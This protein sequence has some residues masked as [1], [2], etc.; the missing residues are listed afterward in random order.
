MLDPRFVRT[1]ARDSEVS[2]ALAGAAGVESGLGV[3]CRAC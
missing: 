2:F 1:V 3:R